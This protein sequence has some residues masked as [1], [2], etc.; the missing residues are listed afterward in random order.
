MASETAA[1]DGRAT[2]ETLAH[3]GRLAES[4]AGLVMV[5]Y[6]Y[7]EAAGRSEPRQL[8][9][10]TDAHIAGLSEIAAR[11]HAAGA[12]AG[13]QLTHAGGKSARDLTGGVLE[14]P[15]AIRVPVKDRELETPDAL[16]ATGIARWKAAFRAAT[17]RAVAAGFDLVEYHAAHGYGLNQWLS[18]ITNR[19]T[20][21]YGGSVEKNGRLLFEI[22]ADAV[23]LHPE[24]LF[25]VRMPGQDFLESGLSPADAVR[26]AER[27]EALGAD[28]IDVSSG[29]GGWRR[30][31]D[32]IG[33]GYLVAEA[34]MI[35]S[36]ISIPVIGVGGIE[37][38]E[39]IDAAVASRRLSLAAVGRALSK[40]PRAW[41]AKNLNGRPI[42]ASREA[43]LCQ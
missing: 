24:A 19:R 23:R 28:V 10:A 17:A 13:I 11:I 35:Q 7:V 27:L 15:S 9:I 4:G 12:L 31:R 5:E 8:G 21:A 39:F 38:G 32:R 6:T 29:I 1:E 18:P 22:V 36:A 26:I 14:S 40:D 43:S 25:A 30:P 3:Y 33:E 42:Q 16:S 34:A 20:D 41:G 37:R 2:A